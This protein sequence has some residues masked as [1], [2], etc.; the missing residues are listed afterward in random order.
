MPHLP[1]DEARIDRAHAHDARQRRRQ[2]SR[3]RALRIGQVE[4]DEIDGAAEHFCRRREA[5]D[6]GHV[7][8]TFQKIARRIVARMD[9]EVGRCNALR[10]SARCSVAFACGAAISMRGGREIGGAE[11]CGIGFAAEQIFNAGAVGARRGAE[12]AIE[13]SGAACAPRL[14]Q[15]IFVGRF[16]ARG[17]CLHGGI[18]KRDLRRKEIAEQSGNAPGDID[19]RA[20]HGG[21]R[22]DLDAGHAAAGMIPDRPATHQREPLRD[23]FA[24]RAQSGAAPKIDHD[25]ARQFAMA[26]QVRAHDFVGGEAAEIHGGRRRQGARIGGEEIAAGRQHIAPP[27][28]RRTGRTRRDAAAVEGRDKRGALGLRRLPA[29]AD[30]PSRRAR[31]RKCAGRL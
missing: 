21:G 13:S 19:A 14:G 20:A 25:G 28:R 16:V 1:G 2:G 17:D 7:F 11:R 8:R 9:Q 30:R 24:T 12:D 3:A 27:A 22:Q 29:T 6:E 10:E 31:G 26:L 15:W 5:A 18:E 4:H 23:L